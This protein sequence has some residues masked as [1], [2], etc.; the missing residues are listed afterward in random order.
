VVDAS[1]L[2][3][4][5]TEL[6]ARYDVPGASLAV[7][8]DGEV[9]TVA[10]GSLNRDAGIDATTDSLFQIGSI[11]KLFTT[12][13]VMRLVERDELDL[14]EPVVKHLPELTTQDPDAARAVTLRHL[15][16]H[17]SGIDGDHFLD[18]G[19]GDDVLER[20]VASC[21]ELPQQFAPG[22]THSYCNAGFG[23]A[24]RVLEV[25]AGE[26]WDEVLRQEVLA[27]LGLERTL[28][29]PEDALRHRVACGHVGE[30][31]EL[32]LA[33]QW[34]LPRS[35]G[36]A[37]NLVATAADVVTFG[38]SVLD[39]GDW[40]SSVSIERLLEPQ[41]AVP[42]PYT[43]G[44]QW[45]VGWVLDSSVDGR[46]VVGHDGST[47]GQGAALRVVPD[48]DVAVALLLNGGGMVDLTDTVLREVLLE[49]AGVEL[50][51]RLEPV[52]D[53]DGGDRSR[54]AGTY[55]RSAET[56]EIEPDGD[57]ALRVTVTDTSHLAHLRDEEAE[58]VE[59]RPVAENTY[60]GRRTGT[61][62]WSPWVF[63]ELDGDPWLHVGARAFPR[64]GP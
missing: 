39:A 22:T 20:Y 51:A 15:L 63:F 27:P 47:I 8:H 18:T 38:R 45:G 33:P 19:R 31:G 9:T 64:V 40:L 23:V 14:D 35:T 46:A 36:P 43:M 10:V 56:L 16:T 61:E 2:E 58:V 26:V 50:R 24:G 11:T 21:A 7:L 17:T 1:A 6:T 44:A 4:R 49:T 52:D 59:L 34:G 25:V 13:A 48:R 53:A 41:V 37:G 55:Q 42:N 12:A 29:L 57:T 54:Q 62:A 60:V 30:P 3:R 5:L 28:S 32:K